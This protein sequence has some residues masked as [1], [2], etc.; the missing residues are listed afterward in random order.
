[1]TRH[2]GADEK[3]WAP[4]SQAIIRQHGFR[5][6]EQRVTH[7]S[8]SAAA[9]DRTPFSYGSHTSRPATVTP[10]VEG[11]DNFPALKT[12][13]PDPPDDNKAARR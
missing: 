13:Y 8:G 11:N 9:P 12:G 7:S 1:M 2:A 3:W 4:P 10:P 5:V 6:A